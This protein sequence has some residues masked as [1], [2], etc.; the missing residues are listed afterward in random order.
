MIP[1]WF[2][3]SKSNLIEKSEQKMIAE[4]VKQA[5]ELASLPLHEGCT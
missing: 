2:L 5:I 3:T 4:D 1:S